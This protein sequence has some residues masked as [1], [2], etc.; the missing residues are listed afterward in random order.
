MTAIRSI[1]KVYDGIKV[2]GA[3]ICRI[4][5]LSLWLLLYWSEKLF[6]ATVRRHKLTYKPKKTL[7]ALALSNIFVGSLV[8]AA[9]DTSQSLDALV[10]QETKEVSNFDEVSISKEEIDTRKAFNDDA[11][12][13]LDDVA[14]V[15]RQSAGG[16][17]S[18]PVI[19]GLADD[20]LRI[21]V[22]GMDLVASC[23]NHMNSPLSYISPSAVE[24][25]TVYKG[26]SPVSVGGD[27]IGGSI[28]VESKTP[29]FAKEGQSLT[30]G[31]VGAFYQSNGAGHREN[32][33]FTHATDKFNVTYRGSA[34][35]AENYNAG[36]DFKTR[37][38]ATNPN[39]WQAGVVSNG[40]TTSP[41]ETGWMNNKK[42][43][44]SEVGSSAYK[45]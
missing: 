36:G 6:C 11:S 43:G 18:L 34:A 45:S 22:D 19:H 29:K 16:V 12:A 25:I 42:L 39:G 44:L 38:Y 13:L 1:N 5:I 41:T 23:P 28:V 4:Y 31:E 40:S 8:N 30:E 35:E 21:K 9:D 17:S 26:V 3:T 32:L 10:I 7:I 2:L 27:S 14:G 15:A 37:A 33:T 24:N 20:R